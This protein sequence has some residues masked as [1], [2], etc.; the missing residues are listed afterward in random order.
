[1]YSFKDKVV[2]AIACVV[3]VGMFLVMWCAAAVADLAIVGM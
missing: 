2:D 1:M 3:W